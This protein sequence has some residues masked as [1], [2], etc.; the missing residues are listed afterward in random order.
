M[1]MR[2]LV[3]GGRGFIGT[4]LCR[5]LLAGGWVDHDGRE[6]PLREIVRVDIAPAA[7]GSQ[8]DP[9]LT[10]VVG[11][12]TDPATLAQL[13]AEPVDAVFALGATLTS[14]AENDFARGL[15]VNLQGMLR[16]L[17]ACRTQA[18]APRFVFTS[19]IAAFGGPLPETVGDDLPRTPQTSYGTQKAIAE[20]LINDATR[21]GFIDGRVLRLPIVVTRPG[22]PVPSISDR[23]AA[24]VRE[25]LRG[26]DTV[27]PLQA[28]TLIPLASVQAVARALVALAAL[29]AS[30]LDANRAMNLPSLS[31]TVGELVTT[32]ETLG[33]WRAWD[34]PMGRIEWQ[35]DP[36]MQTVVE[37]WP[38]RFDSERARALGLQADSSLHELIG[39]FI[40]HH[41]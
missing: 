28:Q 11:D 25:P 6:R 20:L 30:A 13:F 40:D 26:Q 41:L 3:T 33:Q 24:I 16:L 37:Q 34:R 4:E 29:P 14:E 8:A 22:A 21:R 23:V 18:A 27:C 1:E 31:A 32:V 17:D 9:R 35:P 2:I 7:A 19:S 15:E 36:T 38:R 12:A 5:A 39:Q 10:D